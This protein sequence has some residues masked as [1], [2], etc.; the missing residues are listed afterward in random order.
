MGILLFVLFEEASV[1]LFKEGSDDSLK[2]SF[3]GSSR[4]AIVLDGSVS[5]LNHERN[6][7]LGRYL[8]ALVIKKRN[9]RRHCCCSI[10]ARLNKKEE[11]SLTLH[12][13]LSKYSVAHVVCSSVGSQEI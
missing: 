4:L 10:L 9:A 13:H 1:T 6:V 8:K 3:V 7:L 12:H 5:C 11:H 2:R